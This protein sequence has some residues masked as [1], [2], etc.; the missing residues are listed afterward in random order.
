[1]FATNYQMELIPME[2]MKIN[3]KPK[4]VEASAF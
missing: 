1:M 4:K 2:D 3:V